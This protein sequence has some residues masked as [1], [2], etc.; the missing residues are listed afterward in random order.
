M[1]DPLSASHEEEA[2]AAPAIAQLANEEEHQ[3]GK[4][5]AIKSNPR[6]FA[7]CLFAAWCTLLVSFE[8]NASG[9]V[10][11]I[12]QFRKDFGNY[13]KGDYVI[14]GNWQ[15]AFSGAPVAS[16][17]IGALIAAQVA[18]SIGRKWTI[19]ASLLVSYAAI[20]LEFVATTNPVFFAGKLVN[21]FAVG[22]LAATTATYIGEISP[23]ALR[24]MLTCIIAFAYTVGP[25]VAALILD[26]TGSSTTRWAYRAVFCSQYG[27]CAVATLF[28]PFM[29]ESPWW[30][31]SKGKD[32]KALRSLRSLGYTVEESAEQRLALIKLTLDEVR[33][34]TEGVTYLECF[35][36]SN[37]RRTIISISPLSIQA[38]SGVLFIA[39]Y[40]TYYAQLAGYS[41][42]MSFKLN[43]ALQVVSMF[44]NICSWDL[45]DRVGRR[46]LTLWGTVTLTVI[47]MLAGGLATAGTTASIKGCVAMMIFYGFIYNSTIG[48]TAYTILT[49][50]ATARLRV[51]TIAIG[52]ALQNC[53]YTMWS[54]V[55]PFMFNPDKANL[56]AKI[57]FVF[58]GLSILC[59]IYIF[60]CQP[61][62]AGRSYEELDELYTWRISARKF[63]TT[64]TDVKSRVMQT[65]QKLAN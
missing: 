65:E 7:W 6:A 11:G 15:S 38:L 40:S 47:L 59:C 44:G 23:L 53:W 52:V 25:F 62:T 37:L 18:D 9:I 51:K 46:N 54:F 43:I 28:A 61:E 19:M 30:L 57:S 32:A 12:P 42:K 21:G 58:G 29:P 60:Y 41:S 33:A 16:T 35:R 5:Q 34:E 31:A 36:Y 17:A 50:N 10:I 26:G 64:V 3:P 39:S 45:I 20:S 1:G 13:Y 55:L 22:T 2:V 4:W 14:P 48:A 63:K 56:G 8:N 49:E 27:F 24:G